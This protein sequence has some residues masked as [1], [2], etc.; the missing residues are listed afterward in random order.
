MNPVSV[1]GEA[2]KPKPIERLATVEDEVADLK[3]QLWLS[4][5]KLYQ[6][7]WCFCE[8]VF[9]SKIAAAQQQ[10]QNPQVQERILR[11]MVSKMGD[12]P[13]QL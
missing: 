7:T 11:D 8:L 10:M 12:G 6:T 1:N 4:T 3:L 9:W 13:I 2:V 5:E